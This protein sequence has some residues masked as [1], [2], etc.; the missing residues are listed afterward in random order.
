MIATTPDPEHESIQRDHERL[1]DRVM[2]TLPDVHREV[3]VLREV[4]ARLSRDRRRDERADRHRD[5]APGAPGL[6]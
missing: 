1:L 3:L 5:V 2:S 6:H 4:E